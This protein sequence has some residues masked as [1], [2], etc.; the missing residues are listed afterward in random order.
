VLHRYGD[1]VGEVLAL[2]RA[3]PRL[4]HPLPGAPAYLATEVVHA[5]V[6][7]G[8]LHVDDVLTRRTALSLTPD[9]GAGAAPAVAALMAGPLGWDAARTAR[10]A[11]AAAAPDAGTAG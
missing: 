7:E 8:A 6:A 10:E 4:G 9:R 1:R 2:V 5:V 3:D 11:A